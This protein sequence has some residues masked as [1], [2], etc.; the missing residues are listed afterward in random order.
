MPAL[1]EP[2]MMPSVA[3]GAAIPTRDGCAFNSS[4]SVMERG[5]PATP[6]STSKGSFCFWAQGTWAA[7]NDHNLFHINGED[8]LGFGILTDDDHKFAAVFVDNV[9][10]IYTD[11]AIDIVTGTNTYF[12]A[13]SYD[14]SLSEGNRVRGWYKLL[15][16][17]GSLTEFTWDT[18]DDTGFTSALGNSEIRIGGFNEAGNTDITRI[19]SDVYFLDGQFI[20]DWSSY[21]TDAGSGFYPASTPPSPTYGNIGFHLDFSD[22]ADLTEDS[23][24]NGYDFDNPTILK[25][26]TEVTSGWTVTSNMTGGGGVTAM[27]D[28]NID[29]AASAC[30]TLAATSS[31]YMYF[32]F[33]AGSPTSDSLW[34]MDIYGPN[35][36]NIS[37]D[38]NSTYII[39]FGQEDGSSAVTEYSSA[40]QL[41]FATFSDTTSFISAAFNSGFGGDPANNFD[42]VGLDFLHLSGDA[43]T[44]GFCEVRLFEGVSGATFAS[45][46]WVEDFIS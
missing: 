9:P 23:S 19:F 8:D 29:Q 41:I 16:A 7:A 43:G 18:Y 32:D 15:G 24:G 38:S 4:L 30:A 35:D 27:T 34:G 22:S 12:F 37:T 45:T 25:K 14:Q 44:D 31:P 39:A 1:F 13:V 28:D 21:A 2:G 20:T 40:D 11:Q 3:S 10:V 46:E 5:N 36:Q 6:T 17:S 26:S 33:T 42:Y